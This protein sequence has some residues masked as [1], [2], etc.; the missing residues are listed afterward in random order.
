MRHLTADELLDVVEHPLGESP[1]GSHLESCEACRAQAAQLT[2]ILRATQHV[3]V[4]EPSP[5][6]WEKLSDRVHVAIAAEPSE[7]QRLPRWLHW[8]V[9]VPLGALALVVLA[10]ASAVAPDGD[11]IDP[12][13]LQAVIDTTSPSESG[14]A[15][16][17]TWALVSD[18][19]G[20]LDFE[21][22]QA[23]GI[24]TTPG[25]A[26]EAVLELSA[27]EREELVRL[28]RQ[29]LAQPGG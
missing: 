18:L 6:F 27:A 4:P 12:G 7:V 29:E 8:P 17:D 22:A 16:D 26:D 24:A 23:A 13:M 1:H 2:A 21:T 14:F 19:V 11:S 3:E 15:L 20:P 25:T 28:L 10:L 5:L 9:L